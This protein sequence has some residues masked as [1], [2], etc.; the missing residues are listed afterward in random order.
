MNFMKTRRP[1]VLKL[2]LLC[3]FVA[4]AVTFTAHDSRF[5]R[6]PVGKVTAVTKDNVSGAAGTSGEKT[7]TRQL[8]LTLQNT[9]YKGQTV[10][11]T[12]TYTTSLF[13]TS[14]Y[15]K[16]EYLFLK[17]NT[18]ASGIRSAQILQ[19][20]LDVI[21]ALLLSVFISLVILI[22]SR[23]SLL[24]FASLALNLLVFILGMRGLYH[25]T[26]AAVLTAVL[27]AVFITAALLLLNGS[28]AKSWGAIL[29]SLATVLLV[30]GLYELILRFT[31]PPAY[32]FIDYANGNEPL[33][34]YYLASLVFAILGAVTDVAITIHAAVSEITATASDLRL[35]DIVQSIR[36]I[37]NDIM[38][39]MINVLFF[40]F[41]CGELPVSILKLANGY[42][43][44]TL[45]KYGAEFE[46][47]RFLTGAIGIAAAI[48]ISGFFAVLLKKGALRK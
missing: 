26:H 35:R 5:Y 22:A 28:T 46:I 41:I 19:V 2:V 30:V 4:A 11:I 40:T 44:I 36:A 32:E 12:N 9:E 13:R 8:T 33:E 23:R 18:N 45:F 20:K 1:M 24:I 21:W 14:A 6:Q 29:S 48:P 25:G 42:S 7:Y 16:G 39:T 3:I 31:A 34:S 10:S 15:H 37:S 38:G 43:M 17:L 47:I 27:T